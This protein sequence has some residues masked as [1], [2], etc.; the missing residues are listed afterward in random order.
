MRKVYTYFNGNTCP[1]CDFIDQTEPKIHKKFLFCLE[2]IKDEK[3]SFCELYVR[4]FS[5]EKYSKLYELRIKIAGTMVRIIF[6]EHDGNIYLLY[7]FYKKDRKD[8]EK[9]FRGRS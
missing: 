6:Y 4:H 2:Y 1:V 8:T 3:N 9:S 5:I 7:A